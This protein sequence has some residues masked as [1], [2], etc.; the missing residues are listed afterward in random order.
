[1]T[2]HAILYYIPSHSSRCVA[3]PSIFIS[4]LLLVHPMRL[5][6]SVWL[7]TYTPFFEGDSRDIRCRFQETHHELWDAY[8]PQTCIASSIWIAN[9]YMYVSITKWF[10]WIMKDQ[11]NFTDKAFHFELEKQSSYIHLKNIR[12]E[13]YLRGLRVQPSQNYCLT[14]LRR[15]VKNIGWTKQ[16][17]GGQK[18]V[19]KW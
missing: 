18:V 11:F 8:D 1:M 9:W 13:V 2:T 19:K 17:I 3:W 14:H 10:W 6:T 5:M 4:C 7:R 15:L 16:N 12:A